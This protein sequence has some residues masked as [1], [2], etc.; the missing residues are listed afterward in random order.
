MFALFNTYIRY[1]DV[2]TAADMVDSS[3][4]RGCMVIK[5]WGMG[6]WDLIHT[7]M[8]QRIKGKLI[9]NYYNKICKFLYS[10]L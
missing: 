10:L 9:S 2:I 4:V 3:P 1:N 6:V 8:D 5:P 7:E